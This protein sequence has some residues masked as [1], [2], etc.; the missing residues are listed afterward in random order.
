[1]ISQIEPKSIK[2]EIIDES[3]VEAKKEELQQFERNQVWTLVLEPQ[4][5]SVIGTRWVFRNKLDEVRKVTRNKAK[6]PLKF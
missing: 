1:M 3:W 2:D 6:S 5:Q 4:N